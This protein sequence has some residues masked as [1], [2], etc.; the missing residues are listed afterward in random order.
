MSAQAHDVGHQKRAGRPHAG[1]PSARTRYDRRELEALARDLVA[2][3]RASELI[4]DRRGGWTPP[5][6]PGRDG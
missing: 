6:D 4:L 5:H 2:R 3:G 1:R